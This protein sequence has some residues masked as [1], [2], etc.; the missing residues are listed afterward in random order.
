MAPDADP[1]FWSV[2][3]LH[4]L[5][6]LPGLSFNFYLIEQSAFGPLWGLQPLMGIS[7][8]C[9][10]VP[11]VLFQSVIKHSWECYGKESLSQELGQR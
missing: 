5:Y 3:L 6:T 7:C 9:S 8:N 1:G 10:E 4:L 2:P 11:H